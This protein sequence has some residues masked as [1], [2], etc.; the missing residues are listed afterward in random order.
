MLQKIAEIVKNRTTKRKP[1]PPVTEQARRNMSEAQKKRP[2]RT[3]ATM[4][5][6]AAAWD[7]P[8]GQ[9]RRAQAVLVS[10]NLKSTVQK[11][12]VLQLGRK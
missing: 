11:N 6:L 4:A 12:L 1:L 10:R 7:G 8:A 9:E 2:P 3:D 5:K